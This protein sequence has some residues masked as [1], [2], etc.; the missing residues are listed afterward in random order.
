VLVGGIAGGM[1]KGVMNL[2]IAKGSREPPGTACVNARW[3]KPT[4]DV[5]YNAEAPKTPALQEISTSRHPFS[6]LAKEAL[7][8]L[9]PG[10]TPSSATCP[11][12]R[13]WR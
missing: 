2:L 1:N 9:H 11:L 12:T 4:F 7:L 13:L 10:A 6:S 3:M 5:K 8:C